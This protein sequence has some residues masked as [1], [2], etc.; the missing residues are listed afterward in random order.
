MAKETVKLVRTDEVE[1]GRVLFDVIVNGN[2]YPSF[3]FNNVAELAAYSREWANDNVAAAAAL[4]L[5]CYLAIDPTAST[6]ALV[7]DVETEIDPF[8]LTIVRRSAAL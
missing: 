5:V 6:P 3:T 2:R 1:S 4:A 8:A 7:N